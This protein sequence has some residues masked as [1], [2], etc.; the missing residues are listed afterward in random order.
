MWG[1]HVSDRERKAYRKR[2]SDGRGRDLM[3]VGVHV[4]ISFDS[5]HMY[6]ATVENRMDEG[7]M[8]L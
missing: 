2:E 7:E 8:L 4:R 5:G 1:P 6:V 3:P